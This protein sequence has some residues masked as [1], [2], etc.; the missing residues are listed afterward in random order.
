MLRQS[1]S[2]CSVRSSSHVVRRLGE[3][4]LVEE[5][6]DVDGDGLKS[7]KT[8][9]NLRFVLKER[10]SPAKQSQQSVQNDP[11]RRWRE[12]HS[13]RTGERYGEKMKT[14]VNDNHLDSAKTEGGVGESDGYVDEVADVVEVGGLGVVIISIPV[15]K[16]K[17]SLAI[18]GVPTCSA[19]P[20]RDARRD[21]VCK[22]SP[23][24]VF[25]TSKITSESDRSRNPD[26]REIEEHDKLETGLIED[27]AD[28]TV[29]EKLGGDEK[30]S[31]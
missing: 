18:L 7:A 4:F 10:K 11:A 20:E 23:D 17:I 19:P 3:Y 30:H 29:S 27:S 26:D 14:H 2:S 9:V 15:V 8:G 5:E 22:D 1:E 28:S 31:E 21:G 16:S 25:S 6:E 12:K 13:G 24:A